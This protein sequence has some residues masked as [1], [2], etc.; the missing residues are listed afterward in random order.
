MQFLD[1]QDYPFKVNPHFKAWV[2]V[3][4][5]PRCVLVYAGLA[6]PRC[7][8]IGRMTTGTSPPTCPRRLDGS[9]RL[10]AHGRPVQGA[11]PLAVLGKVALI[12]PGAAAGRNP[13]ELLAGCTTS[14]P[15]RPPTNSSACA[16]P[17][18][19]GAAAIRAALAAFRRRASEYE[20]HMR[21]L[22]AC[23]QREEEMPYNNIVAYNEHAAVLH[24]QQLARAVPA[25][26]RSFLIDAGAQYRGYA[27]DITR[28]Y[29]AAPGA[30]ADLILAMDGV[31]RALCAEIV[32]G[33]DYREVHLTAHG[34]RRPHAR[35]GFDHVPGQAALE[36]ASPACSC[37]MASAIC[38]ACRCTTSAA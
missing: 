26:L 38:S 29:A 3:V 27:A 16:A 15:S 34:A 9:H 8:F 23:V 37:R 11:R 2:P 6:A 13:P 19:I 4:D 18:A 17:T 35:G 24:Y 31:Q 14:A 10:G 22:E 32:S 7:S 28:T 21:Y 25:D 5:N 1:D 30:F 36:P 33:R 20:A 12:G